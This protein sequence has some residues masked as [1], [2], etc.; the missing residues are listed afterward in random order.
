MMQPYFLPYIGYF[1]LLCCVDE[2]VIFDDVQYTR[3]GWINRNR[4][5][6]DG[7]IQTFTVAL[8]KGSDRADIRNREIS[9]TESNRKIQRQLEFA[10]KRTPFWSEV[11]E[12]LDDVLVTEHRNLFAFLMHSIDCLLNRLEISTPIVASSSLSIDRS[13]KGQARVLETCVA[14]NADHYL[15]PIGGRKLYE[16]QAFAERGIRLSFLK[17]Q[18]TPYPQISAGFVPELS[19]VD[20]IANI[21]LEATKLIVRG[22]FEILNT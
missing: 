10:Y 11:A 2:A 19:I 9:S 4:Y 16:K 6:V 13:L 14:M 21:G 5:C 3:R 15:N 20:V 17:S 12:I 1:Q 7:E 18:L 8:R 22:D